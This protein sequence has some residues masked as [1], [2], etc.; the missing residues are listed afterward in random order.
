MVA[1]AQTRAHVREPKHN[2][3]VC[4][5]LAQTCCRG[6]DRVPYKDVARD[7]VLGF[8]AVE[9]YGGGRMSD[10]GKRGKCYGCRRPGTRRHLREWDAK[11]R[12]GLCAEC[13]KAVA[14]VFVKS[15]HASYWRRRSTVGHRKT[16]VPEPC[17]ACGGALPPK[18]TPG[19][20][21]AACGFPPCEGGCGAP[22]P[23]GSKYHARVLPH[24][25][26]RACAAP[27]APKQCY[28]CRKQLHKRCRE[29]S[30]CSSCAFPACLGCGRER[31]RGS[32]YH[33]KFC[34]EWQCQPCLLAEQ[35]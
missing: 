15:E 33:A 17:G 1:V 21:C 13:F 12:V 19:T 3:R 23:R 11:R 30:W 31:P 22:R 35:G 32:A 20:W 8:V 26:C 14:P 24:W 10:R 2:S 7:R 34:P 9:D 28:M 4:R 25:S 5:R 18:A 16:I 27:A 29:G 6:H